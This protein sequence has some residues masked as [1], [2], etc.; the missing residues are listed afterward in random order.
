MIAD[1]QRLYANSIAKDPSSPWNAAGEAAFFAMF[2]AGKDLP[3]MSTVG[4]L[5]SPFKSGAQK[6]GELIKQMFVP[7][8]AQDAA[9]HTDKDLAGEPVKRETNTFLSEPQSGIPVLRKKLPVASAS[10]RKAPR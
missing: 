2:A 4:R 6:A 7:G 9:E 3:M 5:T 8:I 10:H 1:A